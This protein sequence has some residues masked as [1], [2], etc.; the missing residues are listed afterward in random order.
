MLIEAL[1]AMAV[2][3]GGAATAPQDIA[4]RGAPRGDY[5]QSCSGDM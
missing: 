5:R 2:Y 4:P 3:S 1:A